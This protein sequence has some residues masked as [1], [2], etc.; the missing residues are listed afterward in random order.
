MSYK[1]WTDQDV[2]R[3]RALVGS[4]A[5]ALRVSVILKRSLSMIKKKAHDIG[6]PFPSEAELRAKRRFIF[7]NSINGPRLGF[8]RA[9]T[10]D[11]DD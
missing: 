4:G 6:A 5:S 7:E 1:A 8:L 11:A 3:L 9:V 10:K 2:E